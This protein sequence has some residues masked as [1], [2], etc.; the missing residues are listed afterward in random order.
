MSRGYVSLSHH[1]VA[2][3]FYLVLICT[4]PVQYSSLFMSLSRDPLALPQ[5][6][7]LE[8]IGAS[9]QAQYDRCLSRQKIQH[10]QTLDPTVDDVRKLA[11][12]QRRCTKVHT[13]IHTVLQTARIVCP[14]F[15][16]S[17][18]ALCAFA[19]AGRPHSLPLQRPRRPEAHC[20][21]R[22]LGVQ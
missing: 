2:V 18:S 19:F 16:K 12:T 7:A 21:R 1:S 13:C 20:Q 14:P 15:S 10:K 11:M 6:K 8:A 3:L 5:H 4:C 17:Y 22:D 9:L